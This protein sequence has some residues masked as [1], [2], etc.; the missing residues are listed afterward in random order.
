VVTEELL[1]NYIMVEGNRSFLR[2]GLYLSL[3]FM[4][5]QTLLNHCDVQIAMVYCVNFHTWQTPK[6]EFPHTKI[7]LVIV[8]F[9]YNASC[10][11]F[12]GW[13]R[14]CCLLNKLTLHLPF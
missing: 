6:Y 1:V 9:G 7:C 12:G 14:Y 10:K 8:I 3:V 11:Y 5:N 2:T 13:G 4:K